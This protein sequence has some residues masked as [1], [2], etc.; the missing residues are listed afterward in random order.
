MSFTS[1]QLQECSLPSFYLAKKTAMCA[2]KRG[3]KRLP[4]PGAA[5]KEL[6]SDKYSSQKAKTLQLIP[7]F[8]VRASSNTKCDPIFFGGPPI[9]FLMVSQMGP[10]FGSRFGVYK[11]TR[12]FF[13]QCLQNAWAALSDWPLWSYYQNAFW[14]IFGL[15]FATS[16]PLDALLTSLPGLGR[17]PAHQ[18]NHQTSLP[19]QEPDWWRRNEGLVGGVSRVSCVRVDGSGSINGSD[20]KSVTGFDRGFKIVEP[21]IFQD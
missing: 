17:C 3:R 20:G 5:R 18:Q 15:C 8:A 9:F 7:S 16:H 14:E 1:T 11:S 10:H 6:P 4:N 13:S 12:R 19:R 21:W 2:P